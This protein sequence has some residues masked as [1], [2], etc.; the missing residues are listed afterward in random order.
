MSHE[1]RPL[2]TGDLASVT[3]I[4]NAACHSR[5][6]THGMRPWSVEEMGTFLFES[7]PVFESYACVDK[8]VVVGWAA[9]TRHHVREGFKHTAEI[10]LYVQHSS[11]RKGIG[12][13]L[14]QTVLNRASALDLHCILAI[15]FRDMPGVV[16]FTEK[17]CGFLA[18]A[19]LPEAFPDKEGFHDI[20]IF[21]KLIVN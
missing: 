3:E 11:R 8:G 9:L 16:S 15:V 17:K 7:P 6:S 1:L 21:E 14:A 18:A 12:S 20:L 2:Q 4:F 5:E 19:C 10:S 13:A